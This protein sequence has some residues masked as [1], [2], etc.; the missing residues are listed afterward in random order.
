MAALAV[1][2]FTFVFHDAVTNSQTS[3]LIV[4]QYQDGV[5]FWKRV[6]SVSD[7]KWVHGQVWMKQ[8]VLRGQQL[9]TQRESC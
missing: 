3:C 8:K 2:V 4:W 1:R 6:G 5:L 9:E 7:I